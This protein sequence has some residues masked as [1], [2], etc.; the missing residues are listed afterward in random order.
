[1]KNRILAVASAGLSC[2]LPI[3]LAVSLG[4]CAATMQ[5]LFAP[6]V[7]ECDG[8]DA[9]LSTLAV[10]SRK[11]LRVQVVASRVDTSFPFV[12]ESSA[13]SFV[14]VGFTPMGTKAFTLVRHGDAVE[15]ENLMGPAL[16]VPPRNVMADLLA[17]SVPSACST[18]PDG[19]AVT[20]AGSWQLS[21]VCKDGRP[22]ERRIA[23]PD[24][25]PDARPEVTVLYG[26][27]GIE[28][29]QNSC[30]Y[31]AVYILQNAVPPPTSD[32]SDEVPE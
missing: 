3:V 23:K 9:P 21:D 19:V 26:C 18:S 28:V 20:T 16:L 27:D 22:V 6:R 29:R 32:V 8:F 12:V 14:V 11:E 24:A 2:A 10:S 25:K 4:G 30:R 1:M 17:M 13:D 5:M 7:S 15:V 31:N